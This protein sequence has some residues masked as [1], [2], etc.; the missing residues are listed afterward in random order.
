M[1]A[2]L[3]FG[4]ES[5]VCG[6]VDSPN[7]GFGGEGAGGEGGGD[8]EGPVDPEVPE[9][10]PYIVA[11]S[12]PTMDT[13]ARMAAPTAFRLA[14]HRTD[15]DAKWTPIRIADANASI[16]NAAKPSVAASKSKSG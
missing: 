6:G 3:R 15:T 13:M 11:V 9:L 10:E 2:D 5:S 16:S 1:T 12:W 4:V 8:G 14:S 7:T